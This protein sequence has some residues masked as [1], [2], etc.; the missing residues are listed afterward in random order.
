MAILIDFCYSDK[1][2]HKLVESNSSYAFYSS[3][4]GYNSFLAFYFLLFQFSGL[5]VLNEEAS[6]LDRDSGVL[7][8]ACTDEGL[9]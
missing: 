6:L 3:W 4:S 8:A 5:S 2:W 9:K 7:W 1:R